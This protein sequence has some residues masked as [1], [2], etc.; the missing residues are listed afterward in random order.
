MSLLIEPGFGGQDGCGHVLW[1]KRLPEVWS[2]A[3][4]GVVGMPSE[5]WQGLVWAAAEH[6]L[7]PIC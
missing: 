2:G 6:V 1:K 3:E 4:D 7:P 5:N